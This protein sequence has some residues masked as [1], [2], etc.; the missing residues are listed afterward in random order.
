[1]VQQVDINGQIHEFPDE[2]T[3]EMMEA[4]LKKESAS[5]KIMNLEENNILSKRNINKLVNEKLVSDYSDPRLLTLKGLRRRGFTPS[6]IK[7]I[8]ETSSMERNARRVLSFDF[9]VSS[10]AIRAPSMPSKSSIC[11]LAVSGF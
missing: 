6:M 11:G 1:M 10:R 4:A 8:V 3:P 9:N 7:S 2:A 5:Q